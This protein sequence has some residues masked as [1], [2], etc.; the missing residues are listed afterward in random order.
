MV[1]HETAIAADFLLRYISFQ[2][3]Q[4]CQVFRDALLNVWQTQFLN[5]WFPETPIRANALRAIDFI[6]GRIH[7]SLLK[8]V[9]LCGIEMPEF[10]I[11]ADLVIWIDPNCVAYRV[12]DNGYMTTLYD[13]ENSVQYSPPFV[14][15]SPTFRTMINVY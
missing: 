6:D 5:Y 10:K 14:H 2:K 11:P 7:P 1:H 8:A 13:T 12:G 9:E 4:D 15:K 3:D